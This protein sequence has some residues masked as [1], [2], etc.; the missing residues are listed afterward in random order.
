MLRT[1]DNESRCFPRVDF[2]AHATLVTTHHTWPVHILDLSFNGALAALIYKHD[3]E[4]GEQI[5]LTIEVGEEEKIKMQG[6]LAHQQGHFLGLECH[7]KSIDH[8]SKLRELLDNYKADT[9]HHFRSLTELLQ[10]H[11]QREPTNI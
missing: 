4:N 11:E 7:A 3:M 5:I 9:S 8:Q 2:R 6:H 1:T 10:D